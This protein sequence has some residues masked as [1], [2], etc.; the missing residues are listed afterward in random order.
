MEKNEEPYDV[1]VIGGGAS[2]MMAAIAAAKNGKHVLL[3]EK[4]KKLGEKL[5]ITG[6]KRCNI[7][8]A[9][10]DEKVL[11]KFYG[12]AA[13]FLHSPFSQFGVQ[14]TFTF[15]ESRGL[16]LVI[17]DKKRAFPHTEK[18]SDVVAVLEKSLHDLGVHIQTDVSV[19]HIMG[20]D[21]SIQYVIAGGK[22]YHA[23]SYILATGGTSHPE[24]GSTGDGFRFLR[25]LGHTVIDPTP[26]L[27]PLSVVD[28]WVKKLAGVTISMMKIT[29]FV[30]Q[31]KSFA[32]KGRILLTHFGLSGPL[33]LNAARRVEDLMHEGAVTATIDL[34]PER[35]L[36]ELDKDVLS[37]FES[38]KNRNLKNALVDIVPAGMTNALTSEVFVDLDPDKK[39]HSITVAERKYIVHTL[40]SLPITITGL[41]GLDR[42]VVADGGVLLS[43]IDTR[44]LGS[45]LYKNLFVTGDLLNIN[46]P[47]GGYSLQLCWT[48]GY[49]AGFHAK[50]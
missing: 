11:L 37:V 13:K 10:F 44:T 32:E 6:G 50:D 27:V 35:N 14:D 43:E 8:N 46:R 30:N 40:K 36:G 22:K 33:I 12:D 23:A 31:K 1:I 48:T 17:Q 34:F 3:L 19:E 49:V 2:G 28:A 16:P 24:T 4:N 29:F 20:S 9:E 5:R 39:V 15:F 18:A 26:N 42:A 7:T 47:T 45:R 41:M 25:D 21:G 38:Q